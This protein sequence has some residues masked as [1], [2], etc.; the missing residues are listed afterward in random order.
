MDTMSETPKGSFALEEPQGGPS[1]LTGIRADSG[2]ADAAAPGFDLLSKFCLWPWC[3]F[4]G[5][6]VLYI[7]LCSAVF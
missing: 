5:A 4:R 2:K 6:L 1:L 3:P 7:P